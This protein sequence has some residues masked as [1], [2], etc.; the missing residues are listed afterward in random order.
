MAVTVTVVKGPDK[1][2]ATWT[3]DASGGNGPGVDFSGYVNRAVQRISGTATLTVEGSNDNTTF[4]AHST[5]I[6]AA[7]DAAIRTVADNPIYER[8]VLSAAVG[9]AVMVGHKPSR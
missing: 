5:A 6:S 9:V 4:G 7:N 8:V 3:G 1:M 2:I